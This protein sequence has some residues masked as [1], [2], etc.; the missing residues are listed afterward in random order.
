MPRPGPQTKVRTRLG[1]YRVALGLTQKE[2]AWAIGI[3]IALYVRLERGQHRN[4]RLGW[5]VNAS[6][7]LGVGLE[8][9]MDDWMSGWYSGDG[10]DRPKP[11]PS[12]WSARPEVLARAERYRHQEQEKPAS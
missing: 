6:I 12:E 7:V 1:A 3:P 5:L 8:D 10:F 4:P 11:P 9:V 2:M